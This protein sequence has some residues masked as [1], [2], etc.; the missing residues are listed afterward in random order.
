[1]N[2]VKLTVNEA[3]RGKNKK[4]DLKERGFEDIQ[5]S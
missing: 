3:R 1:M 2:V 5:G 4:M